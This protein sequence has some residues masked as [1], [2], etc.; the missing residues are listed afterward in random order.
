MR[1]SV[2]GTVLERPG[3][4]VA[5]E[6][7]LVHWLERARAGDIDRAAVHACVEGRGLERWLSAMEAIVVAAARR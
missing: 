5:L 4:P 6:R 3:D 1:E 2:G 7:A